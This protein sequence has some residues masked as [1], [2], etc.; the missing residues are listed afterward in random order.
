[1]PLV[2]KCRAR[3][4][5]ICLIAHKNKKISFPFSEKHILV[6]WLYNQFAVNQRASVRRYLLCGN[7]AADTLHTSVREEHYIVTKIDRFSH[8]AYCYA[9]V[10]G[11]VNLAVFFVKSRCVIEYCGV[12]LGRLTEYPQSIIAC[13]KTSYACLIESFSVIVLIA[14]IAGI[15]QTAMPDSV[16]IIGIARKEHSVIEHLQDIALENSVSVTADSSAELNNY[17]VLSVC[18]RRSRRSIECYYAPAVVHTKISRF[19]A[20]YSNFGHDL[21]NVCSIKMILHRCSVSEK[22]V[23]APCLQHIDILIFCA[24]AHRL[25]AYC[26]SRHISLDILD[27]Q[28]VI[29]KIVCPVLEIPLVL[30][31]KSLTSRRL[32]T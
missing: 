24:A 3:I 25:S 18:Q 2:V 20:V 14:A 1:M 9:G 19:L 15:V 7:I 21:V 31:D 8:A 5:Q 32:D 17:I 27:S 4:S 16:G 6:F 26:C 30:I 28:S 22:T 10:R 23:F 11:G 29:L 13:H 12:G